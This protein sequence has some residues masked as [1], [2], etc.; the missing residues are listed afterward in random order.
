M[1]VAGAYWRGDSN[2]PML[3]RIYGTAF[4]SQADLQ[5]YLN[6]LEEAEKRDHRKL[7]KALNL[8]HMQRKRQVRFFIRMVG[9]FIVKENY[10]R[11]RLTEN[12]K[13]LKLHK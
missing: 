3:Q 7:G 2:N 1:K 4:A 13:R 9:Y 8:F 12:Y 10:I 5:A 11:R 6:M